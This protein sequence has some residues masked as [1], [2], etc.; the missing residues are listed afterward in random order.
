M[1][2]DPTGGEN[3]N[4][5][6]V[7]NDS[8]QVSGSTVGFFCKYTAGNSAKFYFDNITVGDEIRDLAPPILVSSTIINTQQLDVLFDQPLDTISGLRLVEKE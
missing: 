8:T 3:F 1:F 6:A 2:V 5:F 7:G 4:A